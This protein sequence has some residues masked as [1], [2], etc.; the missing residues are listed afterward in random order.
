MKEILVKELVNYKILPFDL[1]S[2]TGAKVLSLG[3]VLTPGKLLQLREFNK[4]Y[5]E[6]PINLEAQITKIENI[7]NVDDISQENNPTI[8]ELNKIKVDNI[9]ISGVS[10]VVNKISKIKRTDQIKLKVYY[11]KILE[12]QTLENPLKTLESFANLR[13]KIVDDIISEFIGINYCSQIKL[14]GHYETCH[15]LNVA[16]LAG[17][18]AKKLNMS[19][20]RISNIVLAALLHD[21]GKLKLSHSN[22][23]TLTP[24]ELKELQ[25][26]TRIGYQIMK[27][28]LKLPEEMALVALEHHEKNDGSGYPDGKSGDAISIGAQIVSVCNYY[29]DLTFNKTST[30]IKNGKEALRIMLELGTKY[31]SPEILYTFIHMFSYGD[32]VNFQDMYL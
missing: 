21:I 18:I 27:H 19:E 10:E 3:E 30:K 16:I 9:D 31:F 11:N 25:N 28:D 7:E 4:L 2:E 22:K 13:D 12:F 29:D 17:F 32:T 5:K 8:P 15:S 24:E 1:Y 26:H 6:E 23:L 14:V 20:A